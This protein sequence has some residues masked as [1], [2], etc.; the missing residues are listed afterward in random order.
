[1]IDSTKLYFVE[2]KQETGVVSSMGLSVNIDKEGEVEVLTYFDTNRYRYLTGKSK[3]TWSGFTFTTEHKETLTFKVATIREYNKNWR[4][5]VEG[6]VPAF[7]F[8]EDLH[9]FY[10]RRFLDT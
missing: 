2:I 9:E 5:K 6:N 1:M 7:N 3:K 8:E 4:S 10:R